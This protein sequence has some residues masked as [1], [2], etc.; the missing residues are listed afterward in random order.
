MLHGFL[1]RRARHQRALCAHQ[2]PPLL[3][4]IDLVDAIH[5]RRDDHREVAPDVII[6]PSGELVT[7]NRAGRHVRL[8]L[9]DTSIQ[10]LRLEWDNLR[11][12][13]LFQGRMVFASVKQFKELSQLA[14]RHK[15]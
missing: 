11:L 15:L 13:D 9:V 6:Q 7:I 14:Q 10:V 12:K 5:R 8:S 1:W 3:I 4:F 2:P